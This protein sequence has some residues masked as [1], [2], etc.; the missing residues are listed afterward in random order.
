MK[1][2]VSKILPGSILATLLMVTAMAWAGG[3]KGFPH[4]ERGH[5]PERMLTHLTEQL[6]LSET[7][8]GEIESIFTAGKDAME[9]DVNRLSEIRDALHSQNTSFNEAEA[10]AL[11]DE[12]GQIT[13]RLSYQKISTR[14]AVYQ[15]LDDEQREEM[16]ALQASRKGQR[17]NRGRKYD[18]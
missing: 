15:L 8:Q 4:Q 5:D 18:E 11:T 7:Q 13:A 1:R 14:A 10:V 9:T 3:H 12:L 6:E 2:F 17:K 16:D